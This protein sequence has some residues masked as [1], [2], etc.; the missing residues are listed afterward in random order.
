MNKNYRSIYNEQ[1]NTWVAV[2]EITSARG[3]KK[4]PILMAALAVVSTMAATSM[5]VYTEEAEAAYAPTATDD[6]PGANAIAIGGATSTFAVASGGNSIAI[7]VGATS[8]AL[9]GI[10]IGNQAGRGSVGGS[11]N[12]YIGDLAGRNANGQGNTGIGSSSLEGVLG[13]NNYALGERT[14]QGAR[15]ASNLFFGSGAGQSATTNSSVAVGNNA[16]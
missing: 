16:L 5:V 11:G 1:T 13:D 12:Y 10:S 8:T 4:S 7:G 6:A 2:S 3:K 9:N 14:G 15:G